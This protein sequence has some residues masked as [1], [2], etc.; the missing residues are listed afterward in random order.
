MAN[1]NANV[2]DKNN[3]T[4][5]ISSPYKRARNTSL[6]IKEVLEKKNIYV[7][8]ILDK[9]LGEYLGNQYPIGDGAD[10]DPETYSYIQ[11]LLGVENI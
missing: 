10:L 6:K 7:D 1:A 2:S 5:I 4:Q 11:P 8:L 9:N 3:F